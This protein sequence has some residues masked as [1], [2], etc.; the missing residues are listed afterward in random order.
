L[1]FV[2]PFILVYLFKGY[3]VNLWGEPSPTNP[4]YLTLVGALV[5]WFIVG[6][7]IIIRRVGR[8]K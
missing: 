8:Q 3:M 6:Y 4:F 7:V 2:L 1:V 5:L